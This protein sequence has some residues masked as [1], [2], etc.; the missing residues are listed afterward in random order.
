MPNF[1]N[2]LRRGG[3]ARGLEEAIKRRFISGVKGA[4]IDLLKNLESYRATLE[5]VTMNCVACR[6]K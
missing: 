1:W 6:R 2:I 5:K 4:R 3:G